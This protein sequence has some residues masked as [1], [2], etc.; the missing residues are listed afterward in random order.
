VGDDVQYADGANNQEG[1]HRYNDT[2]YLLLLLVRSSIGSKNRIRGRKGT[3][4][5]FREDKDKN[6]NKDKGTKNNDKTKTKA[7]KKQ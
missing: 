7:Q 3:C 1:L 6:K 2:K 4:R 5:P